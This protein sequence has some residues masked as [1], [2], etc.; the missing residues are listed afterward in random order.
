[1]HTALLIRYSSQ[2]PAENLTILTN[3]ITY[4]LEA[5]VFC[6]RVTTAQTW[7]VN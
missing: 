3:N 4:C 2:Y 6:C 7:L 1:M 5:H